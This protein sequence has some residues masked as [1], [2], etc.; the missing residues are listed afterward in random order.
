MV[1]LKLVAL[2]SPTDTLKVFTQI[3]V[4]SFES[5]NKACREDMVNMSGDP[6]QFEIYSAGRHLGRAPEPLDGLT[7]TCAEATE[8]K[9]ARPFLELDDSVVEGLAELS[10]AMEAVRWRMAG[11]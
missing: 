4:T 11:Q 7:R 6:R 1:R 3:R 10:E 2:A 5:P 8:W 9:Q